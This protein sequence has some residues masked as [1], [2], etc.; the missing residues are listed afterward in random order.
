MVDAGLLRIALLNLLDNALKYSPGGLVMLDVSRRNELCVLSIEDQGTGIPPDQV[1][2][3]FERYRRAST[4]M[5][6]W[7]AGLGLY[8]ARQVARAHGGDL[9]LAAN[10][11]GG[12]RF[13]LRLPTHAAGVGA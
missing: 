9:V 10:G 11:P 1:E 5:N 7:G 13:E 6:V 4:S 2:Q 3:I 12:C 8:V